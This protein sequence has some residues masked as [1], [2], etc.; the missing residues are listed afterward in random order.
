MQGADGSI[1]MAAMDP[2][3]ETPYYDQPEDSGVPWWR[4]ASPTG[5][6]RDRS[7]FYAWL[8]STISW[9]PQPVQRRLRFPPYRHQYPTQQAFRDAQAQWYQENSCDGSE[10]TGPRREA[11]TLFDQPA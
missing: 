6:P 2:E 9:L 10:L 5:W 7:T 3:G 4:I 11:N 1:I 8:E